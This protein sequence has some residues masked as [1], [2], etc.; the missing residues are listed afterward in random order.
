MK[1][2]LTIFIIILISLIFVSCNLFNN[3]EDDKTHGTVTYLSFEGGFYGIITEDDRHLDPINLEDNL[4]ID[5]QKIKFN[6]IERTDLVSFHM[7]GTIVELS[8]VEIIE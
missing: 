2:T 4:K 1:K 3:S 7:W 6:Y 8:D 5:G